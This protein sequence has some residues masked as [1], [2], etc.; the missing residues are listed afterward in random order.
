MNALVSKTATTPDY[1][2]I[3]IA[4]PRITLCPIDNKYGKDI[5]A[6]FTADITRFMLPAPVDNIEQADDFIQRSRRNMARHKELVFVIATNDGNEFLGVC[7]LHGHQNPKIPELG[8]WIKKSAHGQKLGR[9]AIHTL[10]NWAKDNLSI[11]GFYYPCDRD[12]IASRKIA[13]SLGGSI[14]SETTRQNMSGATLNE[15][16]YKIA[17]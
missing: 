14:I 2:L 11:D 6:E 15:V 1:L 13:Q 4:G 9:E 5:L 17:L 3:S 7:G 10:V 8:I 12:N 16:V